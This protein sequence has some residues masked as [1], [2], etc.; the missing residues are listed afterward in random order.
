MKPICH[1]ELCISVCVYVRGTQ[2]GGICL[3]ADEL[4]YLHMDHFASL[5]KI[6]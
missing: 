1:T 3:T 4:G 2:A 6:K 5:S